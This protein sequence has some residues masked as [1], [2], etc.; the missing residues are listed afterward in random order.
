LEDNLDKAV[1][2]TVNRNFE[3]KLRRRIIP[4]SEFLE[5]LSLAI[6]H[7]L[8]NNTQKL[9][10]VLYRLDVDENKFRQALL[11]EDSRQAA[12]NIARLVLAREKQK[13]EF[14]RKYS[15]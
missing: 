15:S 3:L 2:E 14:R 4:E 6:A 12:G 1:V 8:N 9:L 10:S 13:L 11:A 5:I 7:L